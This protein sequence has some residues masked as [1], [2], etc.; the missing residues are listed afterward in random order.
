M[1]NIKFDFENFMVVTCFLVM[2]TLPAIAKGH[3]PLAIA[4]LVVY[5]GFGVPTFIKTK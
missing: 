4:G 1:K 2:G 3:Y 5:L